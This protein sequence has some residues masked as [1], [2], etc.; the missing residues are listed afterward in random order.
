MVRTKIRLSADYHN[1][2]P[3]ALRLF[4]GANISEEVK[5]ADVSQNLRL[6]EARAQLFE[7]YFVVPPIH[8]W[9]R[10]LAVYMSI[11]DGIFAL[12]YSQH[13]RIDDSYVHETQ[14]A[15]IAFLRCYLPE[16]LAPK[17]HASHE[18]GETPR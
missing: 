14:L 3:A 6:A 1:E 11:I 13:G 5:L 8:D 10:R 2:N 4:V 18:A 12:S 9:I 7:K 16:V 15:T 17:R